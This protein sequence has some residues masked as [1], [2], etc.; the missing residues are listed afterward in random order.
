MKQFIVKLILVATVLSLIII[1]SVV[2]ADIFVND[3]GTQV[4]VSWSSNSEAYYYR[5]EWNNLTQDTSNSSTTFDKTYT[6]SGLYFHEIYEIKVIGVR[7]VDG[8]ESD[9]FPDIGK[10]YITFAL[11]SDPTVICPEQTEKQK[12]AYG[13]YSEDGY[14]WTGIAV[15]NSN[16]IS[17]QIILK[18]GS[19]TVSFTLNPGECSGELIESYISKYG[20]YPISLEANDGVSATVLMGDVSKGNLSSQQ[21][22]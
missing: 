9:I 1:P 16:L 6:I 10:E 14:W 19:T 21:I 8:D 2:I 5:I 17:E 11:E 3:D 7:V 15:C 4:A 18:I 12:V 22:N 20:R 13:V